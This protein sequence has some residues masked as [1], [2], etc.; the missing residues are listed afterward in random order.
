MALSRLQVLQSNKY[1]QLVN[2]PNPILHA[3]LKKYM[4]DTEQPFD[5]WAV[6]ETTVDDD[7]AT[8]VIQSN[9]IALP[10]CANSAPGDNGVVQS[11][12][13]LKSVE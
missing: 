7:A 6:Q 9:S 2:L 10:N 5:G 1:L 4:D 13:W 11:I 8:N 12:F 3:R